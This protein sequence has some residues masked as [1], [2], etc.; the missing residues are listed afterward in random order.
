MPPMS[1]APRSAP[2]LSVRS[3]MLGADATAAAQLEAVTVDDQRIAHQPLFANRH[4]A[5]LAHV[6]ADISGVCTGNLCQP[7]SCAD[8]VRNGLET[9]VDCGGTVCPA[10]AD[11]E[12]CQGAAQD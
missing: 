1:G 7:D 12:G 6:V 9:G 8:T 5:L 2:R 10:C 11:G 4:A 3:P